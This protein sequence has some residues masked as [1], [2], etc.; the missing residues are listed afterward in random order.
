MAA[1]TP[2]PPQSFYFILLEMKFSPLTQMTTSQII[3]FNCFW[4]LLKYTTKFVF[5]QG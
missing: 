1:E 2:G 3:R 4:Q 5:C